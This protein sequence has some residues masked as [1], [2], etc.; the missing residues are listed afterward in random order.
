MTEAPLGQDVGLKLAELQFRASIG[1]AGAVDEFL[2]ITTEAK[3]LRTLTR[4][5]E[6]LKFPVPPDLESRLTSEIAD[7]EK[8]L[9]EK[10]KDAK[11]NLGE[12]DVRE[13]LLARSNFLARIGENDRAILAYEETLSATVGVGQKLDIVLA[14]VRLGLAARD[15]GLSSKSI[16]R[17]N[18]LLE[19]G[20]DWERRNRTRV[21][22]ALHKTATRNFKESA[23]L[24]LDALATFSA[25]EL[26][27]DKT[28]VYYTVITSLVS[29]DRPTLRDKVSSAP[30]V[31]ASIL[32][33]PGLSEFLNALIKC[34]YRTYMTLL[35][36][37]LDDL[38]RDR[39][40]GIHTNYIGRELRVVAYAQFLASYQ[41]VTLTAMSKAFGI[42]AEFLD[43]ELSRF[44]AVRRLNCKIDKVG[45]IVETTRPDAKNALYQNIIKSGDAILN[46]I[47]KL[48]R[49]IDI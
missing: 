49:V 7:E 2:R 5:A 24:F 43:K 16:D 27:N 15:F 41:S 10:I 25:T 12:N 36:Q 37:V 40:L 44:I 22:D 19:K 1:E 30:E 39:Y 6:E 23:E 14:M 26:F 17:A 35:P 33:T 38:Q 11:E 31:L 21:Y 20:G 3:A 46:R 4:T 48:S 47:Q 9:D 34:D 42:G 18:E 45:G 28:F 13:A 29:I 8:Q 32:E